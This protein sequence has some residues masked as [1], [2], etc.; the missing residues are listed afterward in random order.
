M[1]IHERNTAMATLAQAL[2]D[3]SIETAEIYTDGK[4]IGVAPDEEEG[5]Y[6]IWYQIGQMPPYAYDSA[7]TIVEAEQVIAATKLPYDLGS[8]GWESCKGE[9]EDDEEESEDEE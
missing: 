4:T 6:S 2:K 8:N 3:S 5:G 1:N 7:K 9:G